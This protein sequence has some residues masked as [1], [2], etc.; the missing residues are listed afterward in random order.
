MA[1]FKV[2]VSNTYKEG[3]WG[4]T[5]E[6]YSYNTVPDNRRVATINVICWN[7]ISGRYVVIYNERLAG[8]PYPS[9]WSDSAILVL[10]EVEVKGKIIYTI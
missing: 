7:T 9:T 6:C 8:Q 2:Y 1:G 3:N 10:C 5:E 4:P